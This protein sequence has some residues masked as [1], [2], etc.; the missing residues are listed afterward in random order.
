M[1]LSTDQAYKGALEAYSAKE[2]ALEGR[3]PSEL[4]D[5]L[6]ITPQQEV[7]SSSF[8]QIKSSSYSNLLK[9]LTEPQNSLSSIEDISALIKVHQ[10]TYTV[11]SSEGTQIQQPYQQ[12]VLHLEIIARATDNSKIRDTRSWVL[13]SPSEFPSEEELLSAREELISWTLSSIEAPIRVG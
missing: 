2:S 13:N 5:L 8:P 12:V 4:P 3:K 10:G 7:M 9:R 1:W 6:K 11:I